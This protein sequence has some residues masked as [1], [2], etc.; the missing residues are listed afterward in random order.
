MSNLS[1]NIKSATTMTITFL[2]HIY[3]YVKSRTKMCKTSQ[4]NGNPID[5]YLYL[6]GKSDW[7][8]IL[9]IG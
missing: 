9:E 5:I 3:I 7:L 8:Q 4:R 6:R 1:F 2:Q